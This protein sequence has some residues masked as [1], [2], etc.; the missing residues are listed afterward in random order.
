MPP[1]QLVQHP[2]NPDD[3]ADIHSTLTSIVVQT[4]S[5]DPSVIPAS[6]RHLLP[7]T[8]SPSS[9]DLPSSTSPS[10]GNET[11][12]SDPDDFVLYSIEDAQRVAYAIQEAFAV[13]LNA[14]VIL[15]AANVERLAKSIHVARR[16]LGRPE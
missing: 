13:E 11:R 15:A 4:L 6:G 8:S 2:S 5:C 16:L 1:P 9:S 14:D 7:P 3:L 10:G 12:L